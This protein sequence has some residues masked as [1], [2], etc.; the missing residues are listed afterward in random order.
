LL[1]SSTP[2]DLSMLKAVADTIREQVGRAFDA[3]SA[4]VKTLADEL[5]EVRQSVAS[6]PAPAKGDP[7]T[8][9][10]ADDVLPELKGVVSEFLAGIEIPRDGR[11]GTSVTA[12][13]VLPELQSVVID[14]TAEF[15]ASL[16]PPEDGTS[17]T[18]DDVLPELKGIVTEYLESIPVPKDGTSVTLAD[19]TPLIESKQSEWA[20][21]FERR[22]QDL[23]QR[24]IDRIPVPKD[25]RD[26]EDA[27]PDT[28][29]AKVIEKLDLKGTRTDIKKMCREMATAA[30]AE[31]PTPRDGRDAEPVTDEQI[32]EAVERYIAANPPRDGKDGRDGIDGK[33][34]ADGKDGVDGRDGVDGAP[35]AD[36]LSGS[37]GKDG[38]SVTAEDVLPELRSKAAEAA[39][40]II[41][42]RA[43]GMVSAAVAKHLEDNPPPA[44]KDGESITP[45][46]IDA[47]IEKRLMTRMAEWALDFEKRAQATMEK[48]ID[49]LPKPKDGEDGLS[50]E[51]FDAVLAEDGRTVVLTLSGD[52]KVIER[53]LK[54]D[55]VL[56]RGV[57]KEQKY[58]KGDAVTLGGSVWIA[59]RDNQTKPGQFNKDWRLA[60]KRGQAGKA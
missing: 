48:A 54:F 22:A 4:R 6:I 41:A 14:K 37:D 20:L 9:V 47:L 10:T 8:S 19:V 44:G 1:M 46:Q 59:V 27:D 3:L 2:R 12:E 31:I 38:T 43:D 58:E 45:E 60:V 42:E 16:K 17:V 7:G 32:A 30:V 56:Y 34:G 18:P 49:R 57:W 15:L 25:G 39:A 26:G 55:T 50:L 11:D 21:N 5:A 23:L 13:E 33:D 28:V 29:A 53:R 35:G 52:E 51:D 40:E 36:G 24:A